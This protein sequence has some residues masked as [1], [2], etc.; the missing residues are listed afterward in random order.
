[1]R[2]W[3]LSV[4][5]LAGALTTKSNTLLTSVVL[6]PA[7]CGGVIY[8]QA[9]LPGVQWPPTPPSSASCNLFITPVTYGEFDF[10]FF[11]R[12]CNY[13]G[14]MAS[15][16]AVALRGSVENSPIQTFT[17]YAA[18]QMIHLLVPINCNTCKPKV[19][20]PQPAGSPVPQ[21]VPAPVRVG[22]G[23]QVSCT[24]TV[25]YSSVP[26]R[27]E[28][29]L[30]EHSGLNTSD[31]KSTS[32]DRRVYHVHGDA[33]V[34]SSDEALPGQRERINTATRMF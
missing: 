10:F 26:N 17:T 29:C 3:A 1:M 30:Y 33:F 7:A 22:G 20:L 21:C 11:H 24:N 9:L 16:S 12:D 34:D 6:T 27:G 8:T 18:N 14:K 13:E 4:G 19:T 15:T 28:S 31:A 25:S 32:R 5:L 2:M 23:E